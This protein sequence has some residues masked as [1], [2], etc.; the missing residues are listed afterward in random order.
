MY[1][2][3]NNLYVGPVSTV[4]FAKECNFSVLGACKYPLHQLN[5]RMEGMNR[6]GYLKVNK[7]GKE[8]YYA[9]RDHALYCNLIDADSMQYIPDI[10][11]ERAL[12][13]IAD[14]IADGRN[15][16]VVCNNG[17][18][19]SPSIALMYL[20]RAGFFDARYTFDDVLKVF[21]KIY[22]LYTPNKGMYDYTKR[23]F[24]RYKEEHRNEEN[25]DTV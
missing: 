8:Y 20:I 6:D 4:P 17:V 15:V 13:F 14:E 9:E 22:L 1:K 18:S 23:F 3:I 10:I 12:K 5:A 25:S 24:E 11:I 2:I 7:H 16:L 19:R 21:R